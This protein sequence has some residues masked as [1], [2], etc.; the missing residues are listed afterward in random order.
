MLKGISFL[1]ISLY[2]IVRLVGEKFG[3]ERIDFLYGKF[4]YFASFAIVCGL[5]ARI[6]PC[7]DAALGETR[8]FRTWSN[9]ITDEITALVE[10]ASFLSRRRL[11]PLSPSNARSALAVSQK[12][13]RALM[14]I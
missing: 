3:F 4:L 12:T 8:L 14:A 9:Q 7:P 11:G 1:L 10:A 13:G 5:S 6:A 2:L